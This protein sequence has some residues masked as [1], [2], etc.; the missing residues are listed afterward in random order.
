MNGAQS[1]FN[2]WTWACDGDGTQNTFKILLLLFLLL[3]LLLIQL[4]KVYVL[5]VQFPKVHFSFSLTNFN[6][7]TEALIF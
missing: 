2:E 7:I 4:S 1:S 5:A 6:L 3:L